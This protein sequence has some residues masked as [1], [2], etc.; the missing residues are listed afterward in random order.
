MVV[1]PT[2]QAD[3]VGIKVSCFSG[4]GAAQMGRK[5]SMLQLAIHTL[6]A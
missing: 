4:E 1:N 2:N 5:V 3:G 6:P